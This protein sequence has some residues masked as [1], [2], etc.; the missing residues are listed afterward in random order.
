MPAVTRR[1][2]LVAI[3]LVAAVACG[4]AENGGTADP[5]VYAKAVCSGLLTWRQGVTSDSMRLSAALQSGASDV[6]TVRRRYTDFYAGTT[7]R[8]DELIRVVAAAGAPEA[9]NGLGYARDLSA[10]LA[11][12]RK[13]LADARTR[14]AL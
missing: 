11:Q 14:F 13:G 1:V 4:G 7:R 6:A 10:A 5:K 8:T 2:L 3:V 9:D 12:A